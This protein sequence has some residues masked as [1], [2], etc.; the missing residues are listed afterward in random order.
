[1]IDQ[2]DKI[3]KRYREIDDKLSQPEVATDINQVQALSQER[4]RLQDIVTKYRKYKK[5]VKELNDVKTMNTAGNDEE[6]TALIKQESSALQEKLDTLTEELRLALLPKDPN[7]E[8]DIIVEI[9]AGTGG[10]EAALFAAD[11]YRMYSRYAQEQGWKTDIISI[12]ESGVGGFKEIIFE[13]R[14]KNAYSRL[15]YE[16]GVHRVQRVPVTEAS[17]RIHT[18]TATVAVLPK[19]E[20]VDIEIAPDDLKIDVFHS[21]GA[22]GQNVNKVATAIRVTHFPTGMVVVCQDERSQLQNK[23]KALSVLRTR[24]LDIKRR[25][26]EEAITSQRRSQV[27]TGERAEKIRTYNYPQD[28]ISDHR[29]NLTQH[30]LPRFMDGGIGE[31]IDA[32]AASEHER[33]LEEQ[34]V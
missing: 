11:L 29:I 13:V 25:K 28:R 12:S 33:K 6:M 15:K 5:I 19:A 26:Q 24:L 10:N 34:K 22:G 1:M 9:R 7:D 21:G 30:N 2:L 17:G 27:G 20:E 8:K 32:L 18:S 16:S 4:A 14:G 23:V 3:E 31:L